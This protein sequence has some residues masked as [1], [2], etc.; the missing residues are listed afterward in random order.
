MTAGDG[1]DTASASDDIPRL[2]DVA[3]AA[4]VSVA[5]VSNFYNRPDRVA[6]PTALRIQEAVDALNYVR[7]SERPRP[8]R[9][10]P[11][12]V[13]ISEVAAAA[14]VS[15]GTVSNYL[16][17]PDV[18]APATSARVQ[19]AIDA[20]GYVPN[21]AAR[22]LRVGRSRSIGLLVLD[23]GNPFFTDFI[24]GAE[25]VATTAGY[26]VLLGNTEEDAGRE[27]DYLD[28]FVEQRVAGVIVA[29]TGDV[30][31]QMRE[32][33]ARG[34]RAVLLDEATAAPEFC[35]LAVND[36]AGGRM[37]MAH[38]LDTGRRRV[39]FV[40][41]P[42]RIRQVQA[43]HDGVRAAI[44]G[45]ADAQLAVFDADS[46]SVEAGRHVGEQI[47]ALPPD[48][49]PTGVFAAN[50]LLAL[51]VLQAMFAAGVR[52]PDDLALMG[53]DDIQYAASAAVPL[54]SIRQPSREMGAQ[55]A[56]MLLAELASGDEHEHQHVLFEPEIVTRAST[57]S[58]G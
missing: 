53:Y 58:S 51:G 34:A 40:R 43:R 39:A 46:F 9:R 57:S 35:S 29:P 47:L 54:T 37:G 2:V 17:R 3:A 45:V 11:A 8:S 12:E 1:L 14:G 48:E 25:N 52:V 30:Q 28:L 31:R 13:G 50:D 4:G 20:L 5:T 36:F 26:A 56:A 6:P 27:S 41:G 38:L 42:A 7:R 55:A 18:L 24:K 21:I 10:P 16:N 19:Q 32:L 49:R 33:R 23:I 15:V 44:A 22:N